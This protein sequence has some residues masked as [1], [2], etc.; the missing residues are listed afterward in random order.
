MSRLGLLLISGI[1]G[2][3]LAVGLSFAAIAM[4]NGSHDSPVSQS[5]YSYGTR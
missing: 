4:L 2:L 5:P 3:A 1:V